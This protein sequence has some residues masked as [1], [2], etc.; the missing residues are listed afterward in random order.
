MICIWPPRLQVNTSQCLW[1]CL[2]PMA[3]L[4]TLGDSGST[5]ILLSFLGPSEIVALS[6]STSFFVLLSGAL[7]QLRA[8]ISSGSAPYPIPCDS[9]QECGG[10]STGSRQRKWS[11]GGPL[12]PSFTYLNEAIRAFEV[13]ED[14]F[15]Q[16][17][18]CFGKCE[19]QDETN[20][21]GSSSCPCV[22]LNATVQR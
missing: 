10:P 13:L 9:L 21:D 12:P 16:G 15:L 8:D 7:T 17:C 6:T 14:D 4:E 5:L 2:F 18:A 22:Q 20:V 3:L 11:L 1:L 19:A